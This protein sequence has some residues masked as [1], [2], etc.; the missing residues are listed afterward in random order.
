M[1]RIVQELEADFHISIAFVFSGS[2]SRKTVAR[3]KL[4]LAEAQA[5][6]QCGSTELQVHTGPDWNMVQE[7][8]RALKY[9]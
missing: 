6:S 3:L 9:L 2:E 4:M 5:Y 1:K 8:L 7:T